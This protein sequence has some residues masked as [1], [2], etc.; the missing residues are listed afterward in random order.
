MINREIETPILKRMFIKWRT[1]LNYPT[2]NPKDRPE[3][4]RVTM[5]YVNGGGYKDIRH[6]WV[7]AKDIP[8]AYSLP[9]FKDIPSIL[10]GGE[11]VDDVFIDEAFFCDRY[12]VELLRLKYRCDGYPDVASFNANIF[13]RFL[14]K[15][16]HAFAFSFPDY[17]AEYEPTLLPLLRGQSLAYS[18]VIGRDPH[19]APSERSKFYRLNAV[20][21]N[22]F[23]AVAIDL[24][25][26]VGA[27]GYYVIAGKRF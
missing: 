26:D 10:G 23:L 17:A 18:H 15:V 1:R 8:K 22:E 14:A 19:P 16:A 24:F 13:C 4:F 6:I 9:L 25:H 11:P 3:K 21:D 27:P 12:D 5:R 7:A 2:R 20:I